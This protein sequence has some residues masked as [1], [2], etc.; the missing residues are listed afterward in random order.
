MKLYVLLTSLF[1]LTSFNLNSAQQITTTTIAATTGPNQASSQSASKVGLA[2]HDRPACHLPPIVAQRQRLAN[3]TSSPFAKLDTVAAAAAAIAN[4]T[5]SLNGN[6]QDILNAGAATIISSPNILTLSSNVDPNNE[7][8]LTRQTLSTQFNARKFDSSERLRQLRQLL[9]S[10]NYD[11]Y[12]VTPSDEH[13]SE[14]VS[15]FDRRLRFISG[16][17]GS[18]GFA[19][20]LLDRA[21]LFTDGRY[22]LQAD[23]DL[24]CNWW[25]VVSEDP[26]L[27][28]PAWLRANAAKGI[29]IATDAR[30]LSLNNYDYLDTEFKN[31]DSEFALI[32]QDLIDVVWNSYSGL[33]EDA[34]LLPQEPIYVHPIQFNGNVSWQEKVVKLADKMSQMGAKNYIISQ[35][36]DIAWLLNLRGND[37]PNSP[38]FK[39]YL[40]LTISPMAPTISHSSNKPI[41]STVE[42]LLLNH[43][44]HQQPSL[45]SPQVTQVQTS[46]LIK[47]TLYV[48]LQKLQDNHQ[49]RDHLHLNLAQ[50]NGSTVIIHPATSGLEGADTT[51]TTKIIVELKDYDV[52]ILDIREKL[53]AAPQPQLQGKLLLDSKANVAIHVLAKSYGDRLILAESLTNKLK[54]VKT[55]QEV[56]SMR[57]AHWRDSLA[58]AM[59]FAQLELDIEHRQLTSKWTEVK[60]A[61]ELET[62]RGLMDHNRGESFPSIS[63]YGSNGAIIHYQ[64]KG[65]SPEQHLIKNQSLYLLDCGGQY[66]DGTTDITRT[67]HFGE[68]SDFQR[69]TYTRVL[70]GA[71]DM[72]SLIFADHSKSPKSSYLSAYRINDLLARRH[73]FDIGL[74]Y[75]HGTGHG[76]GLHSMVHESP[77]LIEHYTAAAKNKQL[78]PKPAKGVNLDQSSVVSDPLPLQ[79]NM[80]TSVE[81][82]Y[83]KANDFGIRL[84]NIVV[85]QPIKSNGQRQNDR[86]S[87]RLSVDGAHRR[88]QANQ[89]EASNG[90]AKHWLR[91]EPISLVPFEPKL[92][93]FNLL[94]NK[95]KIWLN[96]YN[97]MVRMRM[98]QQINYYLTKI[99][100]N[101]TVSV[102]NS[103]SAAALSGLVRNNRLQPD[104]LGYN[105]FLKMPASQL[106]EKLELA[107]KW[108]MSKTELI[109]LDVPQSLIAA[110]SSQEKSTNLNLLAKSTQASSNLIT[111]NKRLM[112]TYM[113]SL[114]YNDQDAAEALDSLNQQELLNGRADA[115]ANATDQT[116]TTGGLSSKCSGL[117]CDLWLLNTL[118]SI[119]QPQNKLLASK[120]TSRHTNWLTADSTLSSEHQLTEPDER[121]SSGPT[122][123]FLDSLFQLNSADNSG[124]LFSV[125]SWTLIA[126]AIVVVLQ[127]TIVAYMC[128]TRRSGSKRRHQ[129]SRIGSGQAGRL[130]AGARNFQSIPVVMT[131]TA[132]TGPAPTMD[133]DQRIQQANI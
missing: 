51:A 29:K 8:Q 27:D 34:R 45:Q 26:L 114:P 81:P 24:D 125:G 107:H 119:Q 93:K 102:P 97:L 78:S 131:S 35:L 133:D 121:L 28:I 44:Q 3:P 64:P 88:Q 84:E 128:R 122:S 109:P 104:N 13:G 63:A 67:L 68:P 101:L 31:L 103:E 11:A 21:V 60:A 58:I 54:S 20:I 92:I 33:N 100:Q 127:V 115:R 75:A 77:Y 91:F 48:D 124:P 123:S 111:Q 2:P 12:L 108:I 42:Q 76:I 99:R 129:I 116:S 110:G 25:L 22:A 61:N 82:G 89:Q 16:F 86:Q 80:F 66:L 43:Q 37:I 72:M 96:S 59:L 30:L 130:H 52:F 79:A 6:K 73:L 15:D 39:A 14:F 132:A 18:N 38:L 106:Q 94:S 40:S 5:T 56:Q 74:D 7:N 10:N 70:M 4:Q 112:L 62:Y 46:Q 32:S 50:Q 120:S 98:T 9:T 71:I 65:D 1:L 83:Y 69:E 47:L 19:L 85:T 117:E 105:N 36:D 49:V 90:A 126:L 57:L 95:Q 17:T 53:L 41:P 87:D 55:D 113:S 118:N 23:Q